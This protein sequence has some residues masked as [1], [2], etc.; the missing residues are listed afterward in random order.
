[1]AAV[2]PTITICSSAAFYQHV[3]E[4]QTQLEGMGFIV[5]AP[6]MAQ[7]MKEQNDYDVTHYKTWLVAPGEYDKK[8]KFMRG[9]FDEVARGDAVLVVNDE[10]HGKPNY[11][12][13]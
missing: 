6:K 13:G 5:L 10:K 3:G 2:K 7:Q 11:I 9:H 4:L 12:G 1:M 8:A